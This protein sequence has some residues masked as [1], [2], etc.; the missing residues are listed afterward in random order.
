MPKTTTYLCIAARMRMRRT[1]AKFGGSSRCRRTSGRG[2]LMTNGVLNGR[3]HTMHYA[4]GTAMRTATT[5]TIVTIRPER[6]RAV[7]VFLLRIGLST[8][9]EHIED[10]RPT[11]WTSN[12]FKQ[13]PRIIKKNVP[14]PRFK[15]GGKY[16]ADSPTTVYPTKHFEIPM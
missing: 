8:R 7:L 5:A 11:V 12:S 3:L 6:F 15:E 4:T 16:N 2:V 13:I 1:I 10:C 14:L 9:P